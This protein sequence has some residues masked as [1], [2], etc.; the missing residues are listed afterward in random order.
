MIIQYNDFAY[1]L[2]LLY[3]SH[4]VGFFEGCDVLSNSTSW[5]IRNLYDYLV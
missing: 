1:H 4:S 2:L 3:H 5:H